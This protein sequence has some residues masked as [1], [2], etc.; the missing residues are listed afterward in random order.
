MKPWAE[1]SGVALR[2]FLQAV[3]SEAKGGFWL[4]KA[5]LRL[6]QRES[7]GA[8]P[9][10]G[11]ARLR[12]LKTLARHATS[13]CIY[14]GDGQS[15]A[16]ELRMQHA[17]FLPLLSAAVLR[18]FSGEGQGLSA[19]AKTAAAGDVARLRASLRW[20]GTVESADEAALAH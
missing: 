4:S 1:I 18:G 3:P 15:T 19:L 11:V 2:R 5:D 12:L 6:S 10:G 13:A 17:R 7:P 8:M 20:Q 16:W 14:C 9:I